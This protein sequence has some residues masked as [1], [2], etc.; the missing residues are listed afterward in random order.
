MSTVLGATVVL[1]AGLTNAL[2]QCARTIAPFRRTA[3]GHPV[4]DNLAD[5]KIAFETCQCSGM[6]HP[7]VRVGRTKNTTATVFLTTTVIPRPS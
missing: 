2:P 3:V 1:L 6:T 5:T 4:N 7:I